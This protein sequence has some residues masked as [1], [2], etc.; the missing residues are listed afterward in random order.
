MKRTRHTL[1]QILRKLSDAERPPPEIGP[2]DVRANPI[3]SERPYRDD[4]A[5]RTSSADT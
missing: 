4:L 2:P 1:E 5:G 3:R